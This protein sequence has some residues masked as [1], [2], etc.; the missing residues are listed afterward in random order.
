MHQRISG[1]GRP[2]G[3]DGSDFSYRMVVDSRYQKVAR[4]KSRLSVLILIQAIIQLVSAANIFLSTSKREDLDPFAVSSSIIYFISLLVGE[5]GRKRSRVNFLKFYGWGSSAALLISV[6]AV[7]RS[8]YVLQLIQDL[9][10]WSNSIFELINY[11]TVVLGLG[12]QIFAIGTT[13]SL[14]HNMSPPKRTS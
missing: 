5:L 7:A 11:A 8:N 14:I 12:V 6:A 4:Y 3:T 10:S 1:N 2:S 9:S 13:T